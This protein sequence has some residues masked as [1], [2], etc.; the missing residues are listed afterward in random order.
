M[1][2]SLKARSRAAVRVPTLSSRG[3]AELLPAVAGLLLLLAA[4]LLVVGCGGPA[5]E[6][7]ESRVHVAPASEDLQAEAERL[8][9]EL[10]L[11]DTHVDVPYRLQEE[12]EDI[13][14]ATENGD[15]DFPRARAGGLDAPFMSIYVPARLQEEGGAKEYADG[16]IDMVEGIARGHADKFAVATTPEEVRAIV[17]EGKIA[18]P[19]GM[20]N[21]APVE[22]DLAN[23]QH[24]FDRGIR[25]ITLTHAEN[26]Q[27]CDS[28]YADDETWHGLSPFGREVVA[29]MNRLG[30]MVDVSHVSDDTFEQVIELSK[31]P[32]VASHSS[33]RKFTPGWQR[34][35]SDDMIRELAGH[36]GVIQINFGSAFLTPEANAYSNAFYAARGA[37]LD[38]HGLEPE[39]PETDE[40]EEHY[41]QEHPYPFATL[42]DVADHI[43]HVVDLVG[44]D[45]V[46]LGS[47]FDGVGDSL[48]EGLKDVSGYPNLIRELLSRGYSEDDLAKI[49]GGNLMRVWGEVERVAA[50][51]QAGG[52]AGS[53]EPE[54][55]AVGG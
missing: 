10:L 44:I 32:V 20:E 46:G 13:S 24:F 16:L 49:C 33:C 19:M 11:V 5:S 43:D 17:A 25:Y 21:G 47:D 26:N 12:M 29:E 3:L 22:D 4:A 41:H 51:L 31:A 34:N 37:Y 38:E 6:E 55:T 52:D 9:H 1:R 23:L 40:W 7:D 36:G 28:S 42:S 53:N 30:I 48:P 14:Q 27:I 54:P 39:D 2:L 45:H 50:E 8:A 35:M 18:L 15:F